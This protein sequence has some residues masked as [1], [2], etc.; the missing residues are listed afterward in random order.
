MKRIAVLFF[1]ISLALNFISCGKSSDKEETEIIKKLVKI[2]L[3]SDKTEI[4]ADNTDEI[5]FTAKAYD[6]DN[7]ERDEIIKLYKDGEEIKGMT[8]K[9]N[10]PGIYKFTAIC[11]EVIS[12][13]IS[14]T[15]KEIKIETDGFKDTANWEAFDVNKGGKF[16][17]A[18]GYYGAAGDGR[19]IY[20]APCRDLKGFHGRILRYDTSKNFKDT[21]SFEIYDAGNTGEMNT[22]GYA[23]VVYAKDYVYFVPYINEEGRH[24]KVLRYNTKGEFK[25]KDSWNVF[26]ASQTEGIP[27]GIMSLGYDGGLYDGKRYIHFVPYG[28]QSGANPY[29]LRY[30][31][32]GEFN[33]K[34]S[35]AVVNTTVVSENTNAKGYYG[36]SYDGEYV[37]YVPFA[38]KSEDKFHSMMLRY[39]TNLPYEEKSSWEL[40]D[41]GKTGSEITVGYKGATYDGR[42]IYYVPFREKEGNGGQHARVL[43]YDTKGQ[44]SKESSWEVYDAADTES[45]NTVGYVGAEFDGR[46][47]YYIPYQ[48][49]ELF[50][51]N[52][53]RYDTTKSFKEKNSWSAY[54]IGNID[55]LNTNGYKYGTIM[56]E[57][58]Y[59]VPYNNNDNFSGIVLRYKIKKY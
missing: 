47:V 39:N 16:A 59:Y 3:T 36:C 22:K 28:D 18:R 57:Y 25:N 50:H 32:E 10:L 20:Y 13:E 56:G 14:I 40:Y 24:A 5:K 53:L 7:K 4:A 52:V 29:A 27:E 49:D 58:V 15:V 23:G 54:N 35:W 48:Q 21:N 11:G 45:L 55:G 8:Y 9:T 17:N 33:D 34:K 44:F 46:Y 12:N 38:N 19:Y 2:V 43:R 6:T 26:D 42:Y 37:Y 41:A 1:M 51:A 30:D 31:T